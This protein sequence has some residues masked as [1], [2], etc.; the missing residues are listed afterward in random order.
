MKLFLERVSDVIADD[1]LNLSCV[2]RDTPARL[3]A[4]A[5]A[6]I[7]ATAGC[8]TGSEP[9]SEEAEARGIE[10]RH[11]SSEGTEERLLFPDIMGSG[12]AL[13]DLDGDGDLDAYLVQSG[14]LVE[15]HPKDRT[16]GPAN[17]LYFNRGDGYFEK[18]LEAGAAADRGYGMGVAA[19]DYDNDGDVDLYVTNVGPNVLLRNDGGGHFE[20]A[21]GVAG[22]GHGGFGTSAAFVDLDVD[23]D[24]DLFVA[25]YV[26][27]TLDAEQDCFQGGVRTYCLPTNYASSGMDTLY[28][29]NGD[30]T[31]TDVTEEA[32]LTLAYGK[33]GQNFRSSRP[34]LGV[35][36]A[37]F[38]RDGLPDV[39]VANDLMEDQLWINQG[40]LE[41][42]DEAHLWGCD[43][44]E[45]GIAKAGMGV[46]AADIDDDADVDLLVV[47][48]I[49]QTDSFF[50]NEGS[51]F[52]DATATLGLGASSRRFTRF[53][54]TLQDFDND[55]RLDLYHANGAVAAFGRTDGDPYAQPNVLYRRQAN[56]RFVELSPQGGVAD[57]LVHTSRGLAYGDVDD[58]GGMDLLVVNR[59][60]PPYLLM[61]RYPNRG[62]WLRFRVLSKEGRDAHGA[63]VSVQLGERQLHRDVRS[64]ESYLSANDPRVHFGVAESL[65]SERVTVRW[66]TGEVEAFGAFDANSTYELR[67]GLGT[68]VEDTVQ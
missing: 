31:F 44:D 36:S 33:H 29:N 65:R 9:F 38:N 3:R 7:V 58:D 4:L 30:G 1:Q 12:V 45:H 16:D 19:G 49:Q 41:F 63:T 32:G 22:V 17:E 11:R 68:M 40:S 18:D 61:N 52:I 15:S 5:L 51:Y 59:D 26:D 14:T 35:V 34:A 20:D 39:F 25:N 21:T 13:A 8:S 55:G 60:A 57:P 46:A 37:D 43:L 28:R 64:A 27:W 66:V 24:L 47:N 54:V 67:Q 62:H 42:I 53:G 56:G 23:G 2:N 6:F 48:N 10:F 50:R